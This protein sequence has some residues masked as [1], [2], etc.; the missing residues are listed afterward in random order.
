MQPPVRLLWWVM[1][2]LLILGVVIS[3]GLLYGMGRFWGPRLLD[4]RWLKRFI[5]PER[6]RRIEENFSRYG[7]LVL[8]FARF[9]PTIRSPIFITAGIMRLPFKRFL[10]A[11]GLYALPGV[12][13]LFFLAFWFGDAFRNLIFS[14]ERR[15]ASAKPILILLAL[16]TFTAYL[17]Y[18]FFRHPIATG[19]PREEMPVIGEQLAAK[20]NS[21]DDQPPVLAQTDWHGSD[22]AISHMQDSRPRENESLP[23]S[24]D[25]AAESAGK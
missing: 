18:H 10:M 19:D 14:F 8:L 13:L 6:Q 2:P 4:T 25:S 9:L 5:P 22:G 3:D 15:V 17:I 1:L 11:D 24:S 7:V 12:S 23:R 20:I 16:A 21:P